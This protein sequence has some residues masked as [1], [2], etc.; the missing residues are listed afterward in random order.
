MAKITYSTI[1]TFVNR[2]HTRLIFI[3]LAASG[4]HASAQIDPEKRQLLQ[5]GYNQSVE[6][7]S[8]LSGYLFY[9]RNDPGFLRT[10][11]T[12]RL[13]VAPVWVD[14]ELGIKGAEETDF[15]IGFA[16]GGFGDSYNEI[17]SGDWIERES[18]VG[19]G[20]EVSFSVYHL[21]NPD[22]TIP[23]NAVFRVAPHYT[24]FERDSDTLRTFELPPDHLSMNVR[25][26]LRWGGVAPLMSPALAMELSAWYEGQFRTDSGTYGFNDR[27]LNSHAHLFWARALLCYTFS[28]LNHTV[29]FNLTGGTSLNSDRL[30]AYRLGGL[31]PLAS[32]FPLNV[33]GYYYQELSADQFY[34]LSTSYIVPLDA[35]ARWTVTGLASAA[36]LDYTSGLGQPGSWHTGVGV[37]L[38]YKS[39]KDVLQVILGYSYGFNAIRDD[40]RGGQ[41]IGLL[42][43]WDLEARRRPTPP[44][45]DVQSPYKSRALFEVLGDIFGR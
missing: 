7:K 37:G 39:P 25:S 21:F 18:F 34:L 27:E 8:P 31:L 33:P 5:F 40:G 16:G 20:G 30:S 24:V 36:H 3:L 11:L 22:Q 19:H 23:L 32:E 12:L 1:T 17:R 13:S 15:G 10:N 38:G 42:V 6:G 35:K 29:M 28:N 44:V 2:F 41:S 43:Q 26:G 4:L 45:I 9:H 14:S